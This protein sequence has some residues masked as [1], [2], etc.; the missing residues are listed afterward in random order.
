MREI[1]FRAWGKYPV[2]MLKDAMIYDWQNDSLMEY[3]AF[4]GGGFFEIMQYTGLRDKNSREIYESD[5]LK[6]KAEVVV[7]EWKGEIWTEEGYITGFS[8]LFEG[9]NNYEVIGNIY[10]NGDLIKD[11]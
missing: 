10:E 4:D 11:N 6:S 9:A 3:V 2:F 7:V 1:K 8:E 5:I